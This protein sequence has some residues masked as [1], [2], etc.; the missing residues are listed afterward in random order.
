MPLCSGCFNAR[1]TLECLY[2]MLDRCVA[3]DKNLLLFC[4]CFCCRYF[5][6]ALNVST[7]VPQDVDHTSLK[8]RTR[9][10]TLVLGHNKSTIVHNMHRNKNSIYNEPPPTHFVRFRKFSPK[11]WMYTLLQQRLAIYPIYD[12]LYNYIWDCERGVDSDLWFLSL[13]L[14]DSDLKTC[15]VSIRG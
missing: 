15:R 8:Y 9:T 13:A 5:L 12:Y 10:H 1:L 3:R 2:S 11:F 6:W 14:F 7:C 4:S